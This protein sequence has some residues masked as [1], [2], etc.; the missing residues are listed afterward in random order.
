LEEKGQ[1][2]KAAAEFEKA[3]EIDPNLRLARFHLG[4]IYANQRRWAPAIEQFQRA[5]EVDDEA[6]PTYL[7]A[8]GATEARAGQ[9]TT[10]AATLAGAHA[11]ALAR[12]QSTLAA[13]IQ[14]D[15]EKLKR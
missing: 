7:Y 5:V 9:P 12:G 2:A 3:I 15:L 10:A 1:R 14:R 8:L 11:K 4:R 13:S 6:T